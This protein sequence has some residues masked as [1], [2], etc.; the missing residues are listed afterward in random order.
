MDKLINEIIVLKMILSKENLKNIKAAV[1][2]PDE[3]LFDLPEKVLQFG[4]GVLLRGLPDYF[5]DKA[6]RTG[7]FNGR[8]VV[9]KSTS[10]AGATDFEQQDNLYTICIRGIAGGKTVEEN[11][12]SSAISRVISADKN[13]KEILDFAAQPAFKIVISNTTEVGISLIHESTD[14]FPPVSFPAKLLAVLKERYRVFKG[15]PEAGLV[16]VATELIP[17]NGQKLK[18]IVSEL[19]VYNKLDHAFI[20]WLE[21]HNEFCN[22]LVDRIVPGKPDQQT[23]TSTEQQLGYQDLLLTVAEP[24]CLWAIEGNEKVAATLDFA[25]TDPGVVITKDIELFRELKV[26]LLNGTHTLSSGI[27]VLAGLDTVKNSMNTPELKEYITALMQQEIAPAIPYPVELYEAM[28]FSE[29]VLDRFANPYIEHL[30]LN[31]TAQYTM[32][33]KIRVLPVLL[34][35]YQLY[36]SVP[37]HI[38]IGFAAFLHFMKAAGTDGKYTGSFKGTTYVVN[39][40]S[41]A[42]F[43]HHAQDQ[44]NYVNSVLNDAEFWTTDL[45]ALAGFT[46]AVK[47]WYTAIEEMGITA[48]LDVLKNKTIYL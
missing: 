10:T 39:D 1:I 23:K 5:I 13:W 37:E 22:S 38:A 45:N 32:K 44:Q 24:Y 2:L 35:Y 47:T 34:H 14:Q 26:R 33:M 27:A 25:A 48:S 43:S 21:I 8:V 11:I 41:A 16:I 28:E 15:S 46:T 31:I 4:T 29:T 17:D 36:T 30:W 18:A 42:Y 7:I 9:V 6:N 20:E 19:A 3:S 40:D 12:V